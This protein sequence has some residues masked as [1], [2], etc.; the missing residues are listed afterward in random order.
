[1][2]I[3]QAKAIPVARILEILNI[4]PARSTL[5]DSWYLSPIRDEKTASFHVHN[6]RNVWF[7]FGEGIGGDSITLVQKILEFQGKGHSVSDS[8][9]W[10]RN[11]MGGTVDYT[12]IQRSFVEN[13]EPALVVN[14]VKPIRNIAL[15]HYLQGRGIPLGVA[16]KELKEVLFTNSNTDK[17]IFALGWRNE[18]DGCELRNPFFKGTAGAKTISFIRGS[19]PKPPGIHFFEGMMDYLSVISR[20]DGRALRDDTIVLNSVACMKDAIPYI[21]NYGYSIAYSWLDNDDAGMKALHSLEHILK[22]EETIAHC[23]MNR[24]YQPHKDVNAWHMQ[25]LNL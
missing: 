2:N 18:D 24:L 15:I 17:S 6:E 23:P 3:E 9:K 14:S 4:Q 7:D 20:R 16:R 8:L 1:M 5:K 11:T 19:Q 25:R 10:L 22:S 13:K 12:P 21:S